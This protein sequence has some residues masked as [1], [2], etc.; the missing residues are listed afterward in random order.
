MKIVKNEIMQ[1]YLFNNLINDSSN[2]SI[3]YL[4][5]LIIPVII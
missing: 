2:Y 3:N 4:T 1:D 5:Q